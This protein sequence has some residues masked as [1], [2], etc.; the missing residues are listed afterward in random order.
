MCTA[1]VHIYHSSHVPV[2]AYSVKLE[3]SILPIVRTIDAGIVE[4]NL[5][6][7]DRELPHLLSN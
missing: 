3:P 1:D 5:E 6:Q 4:Y 7:L 2:R